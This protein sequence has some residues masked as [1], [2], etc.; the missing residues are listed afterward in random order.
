MLCG[1]A[2]WRCSLRLLIGVAHWL[3]SLALLSAQ[4]AQAAD[5]DIS[6]NDTVLAPPQPRACMQITVDGDTSTN[7]TVLALASGAAAATPITDP[8]SADAATLEAALTAVLQGLAKSI[9]WDGEGAT[10]LLEIS[11]V[12]AS[13][14]EDALTVAKS[15]AASS[16]TKAAIFG[17]DPNW[18][19]IACAAGYSGALLRAAAPCP[20]PFLSHACSV[21]CMRQLHSV[22]CPHA[23]RRMLMGDRWQRCLHSC[24]CVAALVAARSDVHGNL[25]PLHGNLFVCIGTPLVANWPCHRSAI[26]TMVT[27][28]RPLG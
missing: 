22:L 15:V 10:C 24:T 13:T 3:S 14:Q 23:C 8:Q 28:P 1:V 12:G 9:A 2:L 20:R 17:H 18:G 5:G 25:F 16:L 4:E 7:D 21:A 27:Q 19:R 26:N 11:C 6:T